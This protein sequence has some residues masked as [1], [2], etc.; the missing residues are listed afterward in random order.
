MKIEL[1][2]KNFHEVK[3][4]FIYLRKDI[5]VLWISLCHL[6]VPRIFKSFEPNHIRPDSFIE[7]INKLFDDCFVVYGTRSDDGFFVRDRTIS[8]HAMDGILDDNLLPWTRSFHQR[9]RSANRLVVVEV[10]REMNVF[11]FLLDTFS[12]D[13]LLAF[14]SKR[15]IL[16][17]LTLLSIRCQKHRSLVFSEMF[18][19]GLA[20]LVELF[21]FSS[22]LRDISY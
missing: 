5:C 18:Y 14:L 8:I 13:D 1:F 21:R 10:D 2:T 6:I 15:N 22:N 11:Y 7:V 19:Q 9:H 20:Y 3:C 16:A 12:V 4:I 17:R